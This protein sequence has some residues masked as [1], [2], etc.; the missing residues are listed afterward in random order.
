MYA[1]FGWLFA[2]PGM[3]LL[4][5]GDEYGDFGAADPDNRHPWRARA[6][7]SVREQ[8]QLDRVS[9]LARARQ[10]LPG[11]R[12]RAYRTLLVTE[13]SWVVARGEGAE[14]VLAVVHRGYG[15]V[16]LQVPLPAEWGLE[17]S[18]WTDVLEPGAA[19]TESGGSLG[20]TLQPWSVR[21]LRR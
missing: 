19:F 6:A 9:A 3:P 16:S 20:L 7:L 2:V 15:P 5:M 10:A 8:R 12:S 18:T 21:Y 14:R 17:D 1:A 11:L 13:D 4:Y